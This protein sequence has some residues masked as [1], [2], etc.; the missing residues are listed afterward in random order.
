MIRQLANEDKATV[1]ATYSI[2]S[3]VMCAPTSVYSWD[4]EIQQVENKL[5]FNKRDG[6]Q[7]DLLSVHKTS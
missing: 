1:F 4:I 7:L 6:S 5:F 2:L 3:T